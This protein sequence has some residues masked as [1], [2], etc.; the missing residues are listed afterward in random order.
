MDLNQANSEQGFV[1][2]SVTGGENVLL[3]TVILV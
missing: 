3:S 2:V 1:V